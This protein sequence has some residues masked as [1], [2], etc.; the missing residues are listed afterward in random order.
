MVK[1]TERHDGELVHITNT[2]NA[3]EYIIH[4]SDNEKV[5]PK[6]ARYTAVNKL[7]NMCYDLISDVIEAEEIMPSCKEEYNIKHCK[8]EEAQGLCRSILTVLNLCAI[9]YKIQHSRMEY[10]TQLLTDARIKILKRMRT[11]EEK[12]KQYRV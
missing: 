2:R 9:T 3:V 6:R 7:Q 12:Y 11:Y 10:A 8:L 5:F 1:K 4:I